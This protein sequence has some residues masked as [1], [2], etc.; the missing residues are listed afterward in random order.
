M[1]SVKFV[2]IQVINEHARPGDIEYLDKSIGQTT[3]LLDLGPIYDM[4]G[5]T[6][7]GF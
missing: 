2:F 4:T 5:T 6:I 3:L 7:S 1:G